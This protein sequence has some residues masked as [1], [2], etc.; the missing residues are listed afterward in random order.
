MLGEELCPLATGGECTV[1]FNSPGAFPFF[2]LVR[3]TQFIAH[4]QLHNN[5]KGTITGLVFYFK[6]ISLPSYLL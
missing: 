2:C 6:G 1:V 4:M 3:C 5:M